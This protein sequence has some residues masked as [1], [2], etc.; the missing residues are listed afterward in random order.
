LRAAGGKL[1]K[2]KHGFKVHLFGGISSKGFTPLIPF[3]GEMYSDEFH[4]WLRLK[5]QALFNK[6]FHIEIVF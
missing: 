5:C 1:G 4:N 2:T 6:N 3:K